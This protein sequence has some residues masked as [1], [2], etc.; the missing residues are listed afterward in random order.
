MCHI[1]YHDEPVTYISCRDRVPPSR[2][3]G[4]TPTLTGA[5][6]LISSR[7]IFF[8]RGVRFV[9]CVLSLFPYMVYEEGGEG[10][11]TL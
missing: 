6:D 2:V 9:L 7:L 8:L 5:N 11:L 3:I 10:V 1:S 4:R